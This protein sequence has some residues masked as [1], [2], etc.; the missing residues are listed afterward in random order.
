MKTRI[1]GMI[2]FMLI[3]WFVGMASMR[4]TLDYTILYPLLGIRGPMI[5]TIVWTI[6]IVLITRQWIKPY[7]DSDSTP[8]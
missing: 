3:I 7:R 6:I 8:S 4:V 2:V 1:A 5:G